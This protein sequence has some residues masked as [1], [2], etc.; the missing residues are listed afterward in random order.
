MSYSAVNIDD[1][2]GAGPGG[3]V[4]FVRRELGVAA[5][6]INWFELPP[7]A[8]GLE[9]DEQKSAQEEVVVVIAGSG[10]WRI[11]GDEVPVKLG[12]F[13]RIDP[14]QTRCPHAGPDGMTFIAVGARPGSYEPRGPF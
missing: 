1:I 12:T 13:I 14:D 9:H 4:R 3:G 10:H 7:D 5:F 8:D 2:E 11:G 6:G